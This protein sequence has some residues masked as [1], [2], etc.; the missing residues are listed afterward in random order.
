MMRKSVVERLW[1]V[2]Q[3]AEIWWDSSPILY[4]NWRSK[5]IEKAEN[6]EEMETWLN[7]LYRSENPPEKNI[8]RG[9]TTNPPLSYNVLKEDPDF[10][11][12][13]RR[14]YSRG[15]LHDPGGLYIPKTW[16]IWIR[17]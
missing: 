3:E 4:E 6:K 8:F 7:R 10:V 5:M 14:V 13:R 17:E 11:S 9:V 2:N 1:E 12:G 16:K 15:R